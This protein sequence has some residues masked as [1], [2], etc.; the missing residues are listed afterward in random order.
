MVVC[1]VEDKNILTKL[2]R[3]IQDLTA[4][5][6]IKKKSLKKLWKVKKS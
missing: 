4:G 6:E 2:N 1:S 3:V 5:D